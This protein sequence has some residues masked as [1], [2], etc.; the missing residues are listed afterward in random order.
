MPQIPNKF[1]EE[2]MSGRPDMNHRFKA[3]TFGALLVAVALLVVC[4][5][6]ITVNAQVLYGS[7]TGTVTDPSNAA[8]VGAKVDALEINKGIHQ[9]AITDNRGF[10]RFYELLPGIWKITASAPGFNSAVT[11][12]IQVN[13]NSPVRI[14]E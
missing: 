10:Y 2:I 6:S 14:D 1:Q 13:A 8:V 3:G 9:A 11:N 5:G 7:L 12:D 4:F